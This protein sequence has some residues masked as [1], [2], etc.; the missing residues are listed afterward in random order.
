VKEQK[1]FY[2][3]REH[4]FTLREKASRS[5]EKPFFIALSHATFKDS[6]PFWF[7]KHG[8]L[9]PVNTLFID[10]YKKIALITLQE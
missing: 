6:K 5:N 3:L 4:F 8:S 1:M 9:R 7:L 10:K 2:F